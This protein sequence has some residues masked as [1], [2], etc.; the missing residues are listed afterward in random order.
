MANVEP[1]LGTYPVDRSSTG[2]HETAA[3]LS[4]LGPASRTTS[5]YR[6]S[7]VTGTEALVP[8]MI[9]MAVTP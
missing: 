2:T 6:A 4:T 9:A 5:E 7:T 1:R 8:V 3:V